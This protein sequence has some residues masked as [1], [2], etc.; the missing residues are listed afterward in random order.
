MAIT[1]TL[2]HTIRAITTTVPHRVFENERDATGFTRQEV[3]AVVKMV[4]VKR[5][6]V[7]EESI[8]SSDLCLR[9]ARDVLAGP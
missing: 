1:S 8:C 2:A 4:G 9:A 6:H 7:A 5:R 3:E